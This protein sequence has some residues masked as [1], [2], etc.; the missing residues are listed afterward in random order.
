MSEDLRRL[1][2]SVAI[3][4]APAAY[5]TTALPFPSNSQLA[6]TPGSGSA[7]PGAIVSGTRTI[8]RFDSRQKKYG[9]GHGLG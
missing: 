4:R 6:L 1:R 8:F 2:R 9:F 3:P 7:K 5:Q